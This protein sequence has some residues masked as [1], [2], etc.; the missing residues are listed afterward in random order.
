MRRKYL[1]ELDLYI[2][3]VI[4]YILY[5]RPF[6]YIRHQGQDL[7]S[8]QWPNDVLLMDPLTR[9]NVE[10]SMNR[11][12]P[13]SVPGFAP[14]LSVRTS[15]SDSKIH[16]V[17]SG[18]SGLAG[19]LIN[20]LK[21]SRTFASFSDYEIRNEAEKGSGLKP[22]SQVVNCSFHWRVKRKTKTVID[23]NGWRVEEES[24]ENLWIICYVYSW[25]WARAQYRNI[26]EI[27]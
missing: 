26:K 24:V 16:K 14:W 10:Y 6:T 15:L 17:V 19:D 23:N 8:G 2:I 9:R 13:P 27:I 18:L 4:Y 22:V 11:N 7:I 3:Y 21:D 12:V 1:C 25:S 5:I 20:I